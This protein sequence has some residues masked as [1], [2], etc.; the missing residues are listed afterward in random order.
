MPSFKA[1]MKEYNT[2]QISI[3]A[4]ICVYVKVINLNF[5]SGLN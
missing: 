1:N 3:I 4:L 2:K 5:K